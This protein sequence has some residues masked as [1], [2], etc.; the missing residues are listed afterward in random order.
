MLGHTYVLTGTKD[1]KLWAVRSDGA[2]A[3]WNDEKQIW[4]TKE[5]IMAAKKKTKKAAKA[6]TKLAKTVPRGVKRQAKGR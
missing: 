1:G 4:V 5:A 2:A 3:W 6:K